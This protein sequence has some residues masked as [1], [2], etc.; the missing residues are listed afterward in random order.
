MVAQPR[1]AWLLPFVEPT[2]LLGEAPPQKAPPALPANRF[3][4]LEK[5][6]AVTSLPL[7]LPRS[8]SLSCAFSFSFYLC[9]Q[10]QMTIRLS[11]APQ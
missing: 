8:R 3:P 7:S 6:S 11:Q 4:S 9:K 2:L 5:I 10:V 1:S